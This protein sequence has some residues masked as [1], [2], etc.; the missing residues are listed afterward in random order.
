[1]ILRKAPC[2]CEESGEGV[3]TRPVAL[4]RDGISPRASAP[5]AGREAQ[6]PPGPLPPRAPQ[7]PSCSSQIHHSFLYDEECEN[8]A[9]STLYNS[10]AS[11]LW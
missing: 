6:T 3:K 9:F 5:A 7:A 11:V 8:G 1:M 4:R 10:A 2:P